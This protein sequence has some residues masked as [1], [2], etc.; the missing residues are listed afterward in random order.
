MTET[1]K[2]EFEQ[3]RGEVEP[4]REDAL[5]IELTQPTKGK[6]KYLV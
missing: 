5:L 1:T 2:P 4:M 6:D 3:P